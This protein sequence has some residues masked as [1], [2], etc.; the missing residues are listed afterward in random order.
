MNFFRSDLLVSLQIDLVTREKDGLEEEDCRRIR[1][2]L[3]AIVSA[4]SSV[5]NASLWGR[6][7]HEFFRDY[8][9]SYKTWNDVKGKD[10]QAMRQRDV[11]LA[12]LQ[13]SR[14]KIAN[15]C[16]KNAHSLS[17]AFDLQFATAVNDAVI[18]VVTAAP[19]A[20]TNLAKS[21]ARFAEKMG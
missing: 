19:T 4:A 21:A 15:A 7:L 9:E 18:S 6:A 3:S 12:S 1:Q 10:L 13:D 5:P 17:E 16:R 2:M 20:F 8:E 14:Q 11:I